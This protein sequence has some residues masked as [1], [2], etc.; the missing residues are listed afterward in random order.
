VQNQ[1]V[2][3]SGSGHSVSD[4]SP[5]GLGHTASVPNAGG[6]SCFGFYAASGSTDGPT[7]SSAHQPTFTHGVS[8]AGAAGVSGQDGHATTVECFANR[9]TPYTVTF[10]AAGRATEVRCRG[11]LTWKPG[12]RRTITADCAIRAALAKVSA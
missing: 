3:L 6:T 5:N 12:K 10:D 7:N 1:G 9:G 2:P 8:N 4:P 11:R